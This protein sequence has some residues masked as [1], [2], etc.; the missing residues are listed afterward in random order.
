M[1]LVD[2][3][4]MISTTQKEAKMQG[5]SRTGSFF[6]LSPQ[7]K[8]EFRKKLEEKLL[9]EEMAGDDFKP[10]SLDLYPLAK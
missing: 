1:S 2:F 9:R 8:K 3:Q 5:R 4:A 6:V 7:E 10:R